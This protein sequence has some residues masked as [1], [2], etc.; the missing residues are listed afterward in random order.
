MQT[1]CVCVCEYECVYCADL[2]LHYDIWL[3]G[4]GGKMLHFLC[5]NIN[6][7]IERMNARVLFASRYD[8]I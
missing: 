5:I 6:N 7:M 3:H 1:V 4:V 8:L 2:Y